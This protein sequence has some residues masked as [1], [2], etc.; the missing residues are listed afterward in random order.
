MQGRDHKCTFCEKT[1]LS[2]PALYTHM[3]T[4]HAKG[5]DGKPLVSMN[6]GRGRG[7]PKKNQGR[8]GN[9]NVVTDEYFRS[10][11][12]VGGPLD[13][14]DGFAD[15]YTEIY[16]KLAKKEGGGGKEQ[17]KEEDEEGEEEEEEQGEE[18]QNE[19]GGED[20]E[21]GEDELEDFENLSED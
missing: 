10:Y 9:S 17:A 4:K 3:K 8:V 7:R 13:P 15:V 14:T 1:Y 18:E 20:E 2:Y 21:E 5:P 19:E 11:E 6:A 12:K 16:I